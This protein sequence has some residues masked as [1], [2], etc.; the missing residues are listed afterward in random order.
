[1]H[2]TATPIEIPIEVLAN[3]TSLLPCDCLSKIRI[4]VL[5]GQGEVSP[6]TEDGSIGFAGN[7][8][9]SR[10]SQQSVPI[11]LNNDAN[12]YYDPNGNYVAPFIFGQFGS[13]AKSDLGFYNIDWGSRIITYDFNFPYSEVYIKYMPV[14]SNNGEYPVNPFFLEAIM[15]FIEWNDKRRSTVD[16]NSA[17][18]RYYNEFR[19]GKRSIVSFDLEQAILQYNRTTRIARF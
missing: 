15:A 9:P 12:I 16:R 4:G 5:N 17:E 10:T 2:A 8:S 3:K 14:F 1:M 11:L 19:V 18:K 6:L 13:G 7:S